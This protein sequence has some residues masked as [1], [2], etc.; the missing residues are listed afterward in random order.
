VTSPQPAARISSGTAGAKA[1]HR[2]D[3]ELRITIAGITTA[4]VSREA[5]LVLGAAG[6]LAS[7]V[8]PTATPDINLEVVWHVPTRE[9]A[10][11]QVFD[12]GGVWQLFR[13]DH[14]FVF[15]L[16]SPKFGDLPYKSATFTPDFASGLVQLRRDCFDVARPLYPLEYP[17]DEL[18]ITNWLASGRGV[19]V[20]ACAVADANGDGYLFLGHSGAGK[21]TMARQWCDQFG[22]T[23]LSDDRVVLRRSGDTIW[24][25]G[26]PW[27]G[28][29]PLAASGRAPLTRAFFL[30][31]GRA[32]ALRRIG[33]TQA[34][35]ELFARSFPPPFNAAGLDFTLA[36]FADVAR[37]VPLFE[38]AFIPGN[39]V[40]DFVREARRLGEA[41]E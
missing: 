40:R 41:P 37:S 1:V 7:F 22:V 39:A 21:T 10:G 2:K 31:H 29:E 14:R 32:N 30:T 18:L 19:E 6:P 27:H 23:V 8:D 9:P 24:M 20:H 15:R 11:E 38:L 17:L 16:H 33:V 4:I 5:D 28:D 3:A 36:F 25:H 13:H 12:S 34:V 35:A 26:T